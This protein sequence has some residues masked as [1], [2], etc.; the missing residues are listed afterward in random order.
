MNFIKS[1]QFSPNTNGIRCIISTIQIW[2]K[3]KI[4]KKDVII[5][6][7]SFKYESKPSIGLSTD[8]SDLE[9]KIAEEEKRIDDLRK[10]QSQFILQKRLQQLQ[11]QREKLESELSRI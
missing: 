5:T 8:V 1:S 3:E 7:K 10:R 4:L 6:D 2:K 9:K 11:V